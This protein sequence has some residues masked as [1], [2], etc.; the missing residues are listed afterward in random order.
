MFM[1]GFHVIRRS[2]RYWASISSDML[3]EQTLM[4]SLKTSGGLTRGRGMDEIQCLIWI[5]SKPA[6]S[7]VNDVIQNLTSVSYTTSD[8]HKAVEKNVILK[9]YTRNH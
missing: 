5:M 3:I 9:R 8:Q 6:F 4:Q 1:N 2:D 7:E